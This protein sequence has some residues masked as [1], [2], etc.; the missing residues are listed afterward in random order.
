MA[1]PLRTWCT[2]LEDL[3][4]CFKT[5][6]FSYMLGLIEELQYAGNKMEAGLEGK[7]DLKDWAERRSDL[8]REIEELNIKKKKLEREIE[9]LT[10]F[11]AK[12]EEIKKAMDKVDMTSW[13][14]ELAEKFFG[15]DFETDGQK[16]KRIK[17]LERYLEFNQ[18]RVKALSDLNQEFDIP[19]PFKT[20][21][22]NILANGS[23]KVN[24]GA[25]KGK[26]G[27]KIDITALY[28]KLGKYGLR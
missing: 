12:C 22:C 4:T 7:N 19:E 21:I 28:E 14:K 23:I 13:E 1:Y 11:M 15:K 16:D 3:R 6:N 24:V 25:P 8:D 18:I 10:S 26:D 27:E 5:R 9:D 2:I 20:Y 17:Q